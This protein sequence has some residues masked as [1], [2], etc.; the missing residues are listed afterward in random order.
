MEPIYYGHK[1]KLLFQ[2]LVE[3]LTVHSA[4]SGAIEF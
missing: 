2:Y 1:L 4:A 3:G